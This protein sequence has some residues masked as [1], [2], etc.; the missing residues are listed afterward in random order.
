[1]LRMSLGDEIKAERERRGLSQESLAKAVG[2]SQV[3]I[4]KIEAGTTKKSRYLAEILHYL[5][6]KQVF[7]SI[8]KATSED[9][10]Q[11]NR[12]EWYQIKS[13]T[14]PVL[15]I[16]EAGAWR[17][18]TADED[19]EPEVRQVARDARFPDAAQFL[20]R[21]RGD[22]MNAAKPSPI[23]EGMLVRCVSWADTGL[24]LRTGLIAVVRLWDGSRAETT[25]KRVHIM[26]KGDIELRPESTNASHKAIQLP[27][28][29]VDGDGVRVEIIAVVTAAVQEFDL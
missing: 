17:D 5:G 16:V 14:L 6:L 4:K 29:H 24:E 22:S 2:I 18:I 26:P 21:V 23:L 1:M 28:D 12:S 13:E 3:A 27:A 8:S 7:S 25:M 19:H 20:L 9:S 10:Q 11:I 15:G